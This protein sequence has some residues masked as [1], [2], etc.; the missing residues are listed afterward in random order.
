MPPRTSSAEPARSACGISGS[1]IRFGA[2]PLGARTAHNTFSPRRA[3]RLS[4]R[5]RDRELEVL[6]SR[7]PGFRKQMLTFALKPGLAFFLRAIPFAVHCALG[8]VFS[9]DLPKIAD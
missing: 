8:E 7:P 1:R 4:A 6:P 9:A 5:T 3:A 2:R